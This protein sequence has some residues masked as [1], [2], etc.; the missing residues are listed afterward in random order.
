M[1]VTKKRYKKLADKCYELKETIAGYEDVSNI[2]NA[3]IAVLLKRLGAT[4]E[5][6]V[7]ITN[8]EVREMMCSKPVT[9]NIVEQGKWQFYIEDDK[10]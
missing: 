5:N 8:D 10:A 7:S 6:P 4:E 2:Q 9:A 3:Y 1:L